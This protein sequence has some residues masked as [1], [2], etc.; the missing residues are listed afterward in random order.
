[1]IDME[2]LEK[3]LKQAIPIAKRLVKAHKKAGR[4]KLAIYSEGELKALRGILKMIQSKY[5]QKGESDTGT[6]RSRGGHKQED[7]KKIYQGNKN[8]GVD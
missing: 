5:Y 8:Q 7:N 3:E 4:E 1:V 6:G 2:K